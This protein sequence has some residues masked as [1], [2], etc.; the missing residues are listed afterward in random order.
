MTQSPT[1]THNAAQRQA[2]RRQRLRAAGAQQRVNLWLDR[3]TG[4][5]LKRLAQ[6]DGVTQA[7]LLTQLIRHADDAVWPRWMNESQNGTCTS[8]G[9]GQAPNPRRKESRCPDHEPTLH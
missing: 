4:L 9:P 8:S 1:P 6:R 2:D 5:A 3:S 7:E